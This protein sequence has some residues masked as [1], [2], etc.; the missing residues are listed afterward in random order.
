[1]SRLFILLLGI[2]GVFWATQKM[3]SI[4]PSEVAES[5]SKSISAAIPRVS[6]VPGVKTAP[7]APSVHSRAMPE[8]TQLPAVAVRQVEQV[9]APAVLARQAP[10]EPAVVAFDMPDKQVQASY[11]CNGDLDLPWCAKPVY[12]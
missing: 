7:V 1:M 11:R 4:S 10:A 2:A 8:P 9:A 5:V 12:Q 6:P 3:D